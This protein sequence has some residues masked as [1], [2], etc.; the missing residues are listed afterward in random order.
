MPTPTAPNRCAW[1]VDPAGDASSWPTTR[2]LFLL[3]GTVTLAGTVLSTRVNRRFGLIPALVGVNQLLFVTTGW[4]PAS[5]VISRL[6]N[7]AKSPGS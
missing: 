7:G 1:P 3:A 5:A 6:R 4:C 2:V